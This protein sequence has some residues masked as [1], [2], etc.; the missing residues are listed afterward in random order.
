MKSVHDQIRQHVLDRS[1]HNGSLAQALT[2]WSVEF[3][4][5]MRR[6]MVMGFL[7]YGDMYD[8]NRPPYDNIGS[9]IAR[10][11]EYLRGGNKEHLLDAANLC[12]VEFV[13]ESCHP[14]PKL[15]PVDDGPHTERLS[16]EV[17]LVD[18]IGWQGYRC[19][20]CN[21]AVA[22][23]LFAVRRPEVARGLCVGCATVTPICVPTVFPSEVLRRRK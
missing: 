9:A 20:K 13:T 15:E 21:R 3:I 2:N 22:G 14:S 12:M 18:R 10:L 7:R 16:D 19:A 23:N 6:R 11:K 8:P 1:G 17:L 5:Y 4:A